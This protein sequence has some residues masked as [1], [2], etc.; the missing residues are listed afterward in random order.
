MKMEHDSMN[1]AADSGQIQSVIWISGSIAPSSLGP[2]FVD[3]DFEQHF[4]KQSMSR[5]NLD[6]PE[7]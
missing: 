1:G 3:S 7:V 6:R 2:K 5:T 4:D